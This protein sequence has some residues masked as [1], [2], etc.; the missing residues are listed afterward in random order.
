MRHL[1]TAIAAILFAPTA[2]LAAFS[3]ATRQGAEIL[4]GSAATRTPASCS[5]PTY[6]DQASCTANGETWTAATSTSATG[7]QEL[8]AAQTTV[9]L[10]LFGMV[11]AGVAYRFLK[12][13]TKRAVRT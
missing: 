8:T 7:L 9:I 6:T 2:A 1:H 10:V 13:W 11:I 3:P 5:D 12:K 4:I